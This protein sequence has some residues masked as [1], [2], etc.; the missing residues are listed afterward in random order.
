MMNPNN[1]MYHANVFANGNSSITTLSNCYCGA[2][3]FNY[4]NSFILTNR[5]IG[6]TFQSHDMSPPMTRSCR[7][8]FPISRDYRNHNEISMHYCFCGRLEIDYF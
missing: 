4:Q 3:L 6:P 1:N 5:A 2:K 8:N 7:H